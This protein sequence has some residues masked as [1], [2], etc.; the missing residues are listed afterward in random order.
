MYKRRAIAIATASAF[1]AGSAWGNPVETAF[2]PNGG[3]TKLVVNTIMA[4]NK[5]IFVAAYTFTSQ[6]IANALIDTARRGVEVKI[7]LDARA[8]RQKASLASD[9]QQSGIQVRLD[10]AHAITHDKM[11]VVDGETVETGSFNYTKSAET[12]NAENVI[13]LHD[14]KVAMDYVAAW[15]RLWD[16]SSGND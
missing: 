12:S 16:E 8:S 13:V 3:A 6:P 2:S 1:I 9:L 4:A 14:A 11:M 5:S 15:Q 10:G 7:V